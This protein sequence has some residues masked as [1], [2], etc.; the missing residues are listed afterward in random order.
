MSEASSRFGRPTGS[1]ARVL[2]DDQGDEVTSYFC[3][4]F[5]VFVFEAHRERDCLSRL[6]H[7]LDRLHLA[8]IAHEVYDSRSTREQI[9]FARDSE[10]VVPCYDPL[11]N[12]LHAFSGCRDGSTNE[13]RGDLRFNQNLSLGKIG[14]LLKRSQIQAT[15]TDYAERN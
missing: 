4:Q 2:V 11:L 1:G 6:S 10:K 14:R 15:D 5:R 13:V 9:I 3:G 8:A 7:N 12:T